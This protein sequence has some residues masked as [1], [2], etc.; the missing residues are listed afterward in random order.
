[1]EQAC[2]AKLLAKDDELMNRRFRQTIPLL[3]ALAFLA[4]L[5][6]PKAFAGEEH[7]GGEKKKAPTEQPRMPGVRQVPIKKPTIAAAKPLAVEGPKGAE[8]FCVSVAASAASTRLAWQEQRVK[9]LQSEMVVKITELEAKEA[10]VRSWVEKREQLLAKAAESLTAIYAKMK[11]EA[12]AGQLQAMDDDTAAAIL[13]KLK[14]SQASAVMTEM[15]PARAA[16]LS[17]LL[18]GAAPKSDEKKS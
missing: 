9:I 11:P 3:I 12:A 6:A 2:P 10:E 15:D 8:N 17:D 13:L 18:T 7:E 16:R 5:A 1:V 14:A 4:P